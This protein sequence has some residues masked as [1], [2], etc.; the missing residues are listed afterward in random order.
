[1]FKRFV[2]GCLL[3]LGLTSVHATSSNIRT[4]NL[5]GIANWLAS[6]G[7]RVFALLESGD[8]VLISGSSITTVSSGWSKDAPI[9]FAYSRLHGIGL[10]G[11]LRVLEA[12]KVTSSLGAKL[13]KRSAVLALP[14]GVIAVSETGDLVRL[15][16]SANAWQ[17]TARAKVD[18]LKDGFVSF[19]DLEDDGDAEVVMLVKPNGSRYRHG[20]LGD[21]LEPTAIVVFERHSLTELWRLEL[22]EPF[23]FEDLMARPV[24][25]N[26]KDKLAVVRSSPTG[27]AALALVSL[28]KNGKLELAVGPDFGQANRWLNP[29]V[30]SGEVYA[31]GTPHIGGVL[32]RYALQAN[33]LV[34]SKLF[35]GVSSHSIGSRNLASGLV[36]RPG[37]VV[38]PTQDHRSI[39][40]LACQK[41][42]TLRSETPL[43]AAYSSNAVIAGNAFVIAD[44][45]KQ[46]SFIT[47]ER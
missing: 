38:L 33:K 12:G 7:A 47:L 26:G 2:L 14:A 22:P 13:S 11:E 37:Q 3:L 9:S 43:K 6:D 25:I 1:M 20:V 30:G 8:L 31:V 27:G 28:E 34:P 4:L 41:T 5:P 42:C 19:A 15:E 46:L 35:S 10:D 18:A 36:V 45:A 44:E 23:V 21:A 29:L 24:T 40:Q 32:S 17:I 39:V 16:S